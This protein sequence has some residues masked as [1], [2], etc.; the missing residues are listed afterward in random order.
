MILVKVHKKQDSKIL[1]LCDDDL[2]NKKFEE[3]DLQLDLTSDFY[4]GDKMAKD[5][6]RKILLNYRIINAVGQRSVNLLLEFNLIDV[7]RILYVQN[8]PHAECVN[9]NIKG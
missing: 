1:S 9:L 2:I 5:E 8:I 3:V 6:V 4:K 7:D